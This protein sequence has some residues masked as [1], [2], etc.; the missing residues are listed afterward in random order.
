MLNRHVLVMDG[1]D[2]KRF[3]R[4]IFANEIFNRLLRAGDQ[5]PR[6]K[7]L[8]YRDFKVWPHQFDRC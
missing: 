6:V 7:K 2:V 5:L 4:N 3:V 8:R 1:L